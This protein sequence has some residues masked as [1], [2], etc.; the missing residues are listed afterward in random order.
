MNETLSDTLDIQ[1]EIKDR[2][3]KREAIKYDKYYKK[4]DKYIIKEFEKSKTILGH[5]FSYKKQHEQMY[6]FYF[7][8]SIDRCSHNLVFYVCP[9]TKVHTSMKEVNLNITSYINNYKYD[10]NYL[11]NI[12]LKNLSKKIVDCI[13]LAVNNF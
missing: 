7:D 5:R 6:Y 1:A 11:D 10:Y 8:C 2:N 12:K 4:L 3:E 13:N 9:D